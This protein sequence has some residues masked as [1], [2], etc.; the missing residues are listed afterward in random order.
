LKFKKGDLMQVVSQLE[1]GWFDAFFGEVRGWIPG[2]YVTVA[3]ESERLAPESS[4]RG[5]A[6]ALK[7]VDA[8]KQLQEEQ[9]QQKKWEAQVLDDFCPELT[10]ELRQRASNESVLNSD[11]QEVKALMQEKHEGKICF[12][13]L[14]LQLKQKHRDL[15]LTSPPHQGMACL[16]HLYDAIEKWDEVV[17]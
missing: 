1:S 15:D 9:K 17:R 13:S 5:H 3:S 7:G 6:R 8:A 16:K 14:C 12:A 10:A 4:T 11:G 2:N